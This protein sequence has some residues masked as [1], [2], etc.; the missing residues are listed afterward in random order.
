MTSDVTAIDESTVPAHFGDP[1]REQR[2]LESSAGVIDR[3]D[4]DV[5]IVPGEDRLSW[6]HTICSRSFSRRTVTSSS[7]GR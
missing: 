4:R 3:S 7:T 1:L 5:L 2:M 6:L